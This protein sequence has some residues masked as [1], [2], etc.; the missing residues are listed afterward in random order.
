MNQLQN[1]QLITTNQIK[2]YFHIYYGIDNEYNILT[3]PPFLERTI[4]SRKGRVRKSYHYPLVSRYNYILTQQEIL[5][6]KIGIKFI[7]MVYFFEFLKE[8]G[9]IPE[10]YFPKEIM[11]KNKIG[12]IS[13]FNGQNICDKWVRQRYNLY[14]LSFEEAII[15]LLQTI[16][17]E[18][19]WYEEQRLLFLEF[20]KELTQHTGGIDFDVYIDNWAK[21]LLGAYY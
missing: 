2:K 6:N 13:I 3:H 7:K 16:K 1:T 18:D 14:M 5:I 20:A 9:L 21:R 10:R 12:R 8:K 15:P 17:I 4:I 11:I 19:F